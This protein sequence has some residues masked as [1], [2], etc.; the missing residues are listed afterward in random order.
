MATDYSCYDLNMPATRLPISG[1][2]LALEA[3]EF[4]DKTA[5]D[6]RHALESR[7][8][9]KAINSIWLN[10]EISKPDRKGSTK[11]LSCER[12]VAHLIVT[13]PGTMAT[14]KIE[15]CLIKTDAMPISKRENDMAR[16]FFELTLNF[17][18]V[19]NFTRHMKTAV[20]SHLRAIG[21]DP[22]Q[23][24]MSPLIDDKNR[25]SLETTAR[26]LREQVLKTSKDV[27]D[28]A[29]QVA[30]VL[31]LQNQWGLKDRRERENTFAALQENVR[32]KGV[33]A[34]GGLLSYKL[35]FKQALAMTLGI[36]LLDP[37]SNIQRTMTKSIAEQLQD[38]E[39][40]PADQESFYEKLMALK[41]AI[42]DFNRSETST[43]F[44]T[45]RRPNA[46]RN[47]QKYVLSMDG[48]ELE[49]EGTPGAFNSEMISNLMKTVSIQLML[50]ANAREL[51]A[52][53]ESNDSVIRL[54]LESPR[55]ADEKKIFEILKKLA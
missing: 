41:P 25:I 11:Q 55:K 27:D 44:E 26:K 51:K 9:P 53:F 17:V 2:D 28:W 36:D 6:V 33:I 48:R 32:K 12:E 15:E 54:T 46:A 50:D 1:K 4:M 39:R 37:E 43:K 5:I 34:E 42:R 47:L 40:L 13:F 24:G 23:I 16:E 14:N 8:L 22:R 52:A 49:I 19:Q 21:M 18:K 35:R 7:Y 10:S 31:K 45:R 38:F 20:N 3:I 30:L 29:D